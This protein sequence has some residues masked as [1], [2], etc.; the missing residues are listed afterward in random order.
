[1]GNTILVVED[2]ADCRELLCFQLLRMGYQV[3][4]AKDGV[5]GVEKGISEAPDLIIMDLGLPRLT[6]IEATRRLS[7][8]SRTSHIPI[9]VHTAWQG[10]GPAHAALEAGAAEVLIK[11]APYRVLQD[12]LKKH[13]ALNAESWP[14][15][16]IG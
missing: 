16:K 15:Y 11:P 5:E 13:L 1:M 3:I 4:E 6:G 7:A 2:T 10:E 12:T 14:A 8:D 9:V